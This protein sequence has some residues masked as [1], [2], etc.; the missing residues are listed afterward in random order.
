MDLGIQGKNA[1][2]CASSRGLGRAC[3]ISLAREGA[4]VTL[5]GRDQEALSEASNAC[6]AYGVSVQTV[7]GD[8]TSQNTRDALLEVCP[9]PDILV[10]NNGGPRP[11]NRPTGTRSG[12]IERTNGC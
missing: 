2:V 10:T 11:G 12:G 7:N 1:I 8:I 5:N 9:E 4:N 3:A 6:A